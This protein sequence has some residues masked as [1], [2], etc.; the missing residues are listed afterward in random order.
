MKSVNMNFVHMYTLN[1]IP[2]EAQIKKYIR[3]I[4]FGKNVFC[5]MC[6]SRTIVRYVHRYR[7]KR[8]QCKFTLI[9]HTWLKGMKLSYQAF[10][11][12]LWCWTNGIPIKQTIAL[13][14]ISEESVRRWFHR[15]RMH[16]PQQEAIL[17]HIVQLDEAY[18][19]HHAIIMGKQQGTR[20]IAM[21]ILAQKSVQ[22]H[23]IAQFLQDYVKPYSMLYT[24]GAKIYKGIEKW[25]P[26]HHKRDLHKNFEFEHT[27]EIEGM[28]GIMRTFIRRMYHHTTPEKFPEIV[29][30]FC[31]RFSSP[32]IFENPHSYLEKSLKLVPFD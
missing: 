28:F 21:K 29:S 15:F 32:E 9:S 27:S 23:H 19:K 1:Q 17:E 16:L 12:L 31:I 8:C 7:C 26:V 13:C 3:R 5:P 11:L 24:D 10:W 25:W 18:T 2:S 6:R 4:I 22:R 30:E 14:S 20:K